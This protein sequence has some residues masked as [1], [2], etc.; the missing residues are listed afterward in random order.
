MVEDGQRYFSVMKQRYGIEPNAR[1]YSCIVDMLG[2]AG[3]LDEAFGIVGSM[4]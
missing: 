1:H 4:R 3:L 2:R